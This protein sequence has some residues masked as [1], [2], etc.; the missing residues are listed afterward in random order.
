M[1][2]SFDLMAPGDA[3]IYILTV[4]ICRNTLQQPVEGYATWWQTGMGMDSLI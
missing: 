1:K 3:V 2:E 4:G